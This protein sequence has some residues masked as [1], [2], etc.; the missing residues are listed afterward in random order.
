M[1]AREL[2]IFIALSDELRLQSPG[3][4]F[5]EDGTT[6]F[7]P[8]GVTPQTAGTT[9]DLRALAEAVAAAVASPPNPKTVE[10]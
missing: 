3:A 8:G 10:G 7:L 4:T 9:I 6:L 2:K 1:D 5:E